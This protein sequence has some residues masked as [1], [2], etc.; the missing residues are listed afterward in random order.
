M[1][2]VCGA[3]M[4]QDFQ[5][6]KQTWSQHTLAGKSQEQKRPEQQQTAEA[7]RSE[8]LLSASEEPAVP[9]QT[10]DLP[11]PGQP[12][13]GEAPASQDGGVAPGQ[14][15]AAHA[16]P[17]APAQQEQPT[18]ATMQS[19]EISA[20]KGVAQQ[21]DAQPSSGQPAIPAPAEPHEPQQTQ[22]AGSGSAGADGE[23][24]PADTQPAN[25]QTVEGESAVEA[26]AGEQRE[27]S[28][29]PLKKFEVLYTQ[30]RSEKD[31][32]VSQP[33]TLVCHLLTILAR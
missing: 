22:Q 25:G 4:C 30:E 27:R 2:W 21:R 28:A 29:A 20:Q 18:D 15:S 6:H 26:Q 17:A 9:R 13:P 10:S 12:V 32:E 8:S 31:K 24:A 5:V 23:G 33:F 7:S 11:D 3:H 19:P 14:T 16:Q 1:S